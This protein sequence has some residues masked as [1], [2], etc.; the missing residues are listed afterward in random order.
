MSNPSINPDAVKENAL[1]LAA[2]LGI[3]LEHAAELLKVHVMVTYDAG[4][5]SAAFMAGEA[6]GLLGR[7]LQHVDDAASPAVSVEL[8]I[9]D[10]LP[11]ST[12]TILWLRVDSHTAVIARE[13]RT[14]ATETRLHPVVRGRVLCRCCRC[15]RDYRRGHAAAQT[16][17]DSAEF[18]CARH[19]GGS[20]QTHHR[21]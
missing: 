11:R 17:A 13:R 5:S 3:E 7:T 9:G 8:V 18:R 10:A 6:R 20:R 1:S 19:F 14:G 15:S 21:S 2:A 12:G 16:R 4:D